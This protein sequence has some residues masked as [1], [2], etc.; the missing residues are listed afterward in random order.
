MSITLKYGRMNQSFEPK[1]YPLLHHADAFARQLEAAG[2]PEGVWSGQCF[3]WGSNVET[4]RLWPAKDGSATAFKF[5]AK[6]AQL[7]V[8]D[9]LPDE[10]VQAIKNTMEKS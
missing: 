10:L 9:P 5:S 7:H 3:R 2:L 8:G 6:I 1:Q 4:V